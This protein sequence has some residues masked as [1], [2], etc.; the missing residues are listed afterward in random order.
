MTIYDFNI[1]KTNGERM[2]LYHFKDKVVLIVNTASKCTFTPQFED[3]QKLYDQYHALGV[4]IIGFPCNQFG[5][6]E[7]GSNQEASSFCQI[8][9]GV[10]FPIAA[11]LEVNGE[12]AH[13][14]FD[15]LKRA[16]PFQGFDEANFNAKLLKMMITEKSP[17]WLYGDSIK[18][19]F[20]KFLIDQEGKVI[21]RFEPTDELDILK[22]SID[23]LLQTGVA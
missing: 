22:S 7:P 3:L 16:A 5:E 20:T 1:V 4:E 19:N 11:K 10:K 23:E 18:W 21:R 17:E 14:L 9:Y 12:H 6:Q 15:Y 13:P 8:N 2:P